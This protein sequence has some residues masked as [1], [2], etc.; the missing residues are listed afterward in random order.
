MTN[1]QNTMCNNKGSNTSKLTS[2]KNII[3]YTKI[4]CKQE[5]HAL[6]S[7]SDITKAE[8]VF[9]YTYSYIS[10]LAVRRADD[11]CSML[12]SS[13]HGPP[14]R[15]FTSSSLPSI[16]TNVPPLQVPLNNIFKSEAWTTLVSCSWT[17]YIYISLENRQCTWQSSGTW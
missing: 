12:W 11:D 16:K 8:T 1:Q 9:I 13:N 3:P 5:L 14:D 6:R 7:L 4:I 17:Q 2:N 10:S 15:P